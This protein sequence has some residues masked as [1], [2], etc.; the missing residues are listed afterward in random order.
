M[1]LSAAPHSKELDMLVFIRSV[2]HALRL[3]SRFLISFFNWRG[4]VGVNL[5]KRHKWQDDIAA[6]VELYNN[7]FLDF[8]PETYRTEREKA[9]KEVE[10]MLTR[11]VH[12]RS[13]TP[14]ELRAHPKMLF[15][16]RMST[17][18]PIA[19]DRLIGLA[20]VSKSLV[21][22]MEKDGILPPQM[23]EATL[24][25][26]LQK[27]TDMIMRLADRDIFPWLA[28]N[29]V[30]SEQ[31]TGRAATIIADRLCGANADFIVRN[32]QESRQL[33][34]IKT[35]LEGR[36]YTDVSGKC[37]LGKM[38][39][40]TF[41]FRLNAPGLKEDNQ[42][43]NIPIDAVIMPLTA[44]EGDLPILVEAKSAGDFTNTNKRR[45]EEAMKASQLR[46][47]YGQDVR[48]I[49]FLCGY[50]DSGYL[51]YEAAERI[52]WVWEHRMEELAEFGL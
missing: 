44:K 7:W 28:E 40:G 15:A 12:L 24:T 19:R 10:A 26:N 27:I 1:S 49:L 48:F 34:K 6:S 9:A 16:L 32:A 35:W 50:F 52:D 5:D 45:K 42:S 46:R 41:A 14:T 51:D 30:P 25:E 4:T 2:W 33:S 39:P 47:K 43:V 17:A 21:G 36:G 11:T 13:L 23:D 31:E 29:R 20:N 3:L 22:T 38:L 8:A 37:N 18:P